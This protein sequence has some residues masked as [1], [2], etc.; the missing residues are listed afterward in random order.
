MGRTIRTVL[1][2]AALAC[3]LAACEIRA[4]IA[5][6]DGGSGT[7]AT[8][9]AIEP[10]MIALF[11]E[12]GFGADPFEDVRRDLA[13]DPVE[14]D[15]DE[16]TQGRL[17]GIRATFSFSSTDDLLDK[18]EALNSADGSDA[19]LEDFLVERDGGGWRFEG[20]A[21]DAQAEL[22]QDAP[23]PI[24]QLE[25]FLKFEFRITL[26]GRAA[27]HNVDRVVAGNGR[28]TFVW[29]PSLKEPAPDFVASTSPGGASSPVLPIALGIAALAV[30]PT[31][32]L[33]SQRRSPEMPSETV[34][35]APADAEPMKTP[36]EDASLNG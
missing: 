32:S 7:F 31:L 23:I 6:E 15:V 9:F 5:I 28:T 34:V 17:S 30:A 22:S 24:E 10:E 2:I 11:N 16:F 29:T 3:V 12:S 19:A 8:V 35:G 4:E 14:W 25:G 18:V 27:E 36:T 26:P 33:R 21:A 20:R 13:D 1:T